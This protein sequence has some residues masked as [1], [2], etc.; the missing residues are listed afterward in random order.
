MQAVFKMI[1]CWYLY[2]LL[3]NQK[4]YYVGITNDI[5]HRFFEHIQKRSFYTKQF[6]DIRFVYAERYLSKHKSAKREKQIKGWSRAKKK[7]LIEG[8]LGV[9]T[10]TEFVEVLL[11][12]DENL[13]SLL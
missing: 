10:C 13:V 9:N 3:C 1:N 5:K 11:G 8:E 6:S 12:K 2:I 7:K 4:T